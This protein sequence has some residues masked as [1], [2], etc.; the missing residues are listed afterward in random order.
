[1]LTFSALSLMAL[2]LLLLL[3]QFSLTM[4]QRSEEATLT[5]DAIV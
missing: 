1:M 5:L 3:L 2:G 4:G